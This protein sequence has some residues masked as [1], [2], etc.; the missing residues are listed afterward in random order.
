M[1][2][3]EKV[4]LFID[5]HHLDDFTY[6]VNTDKD[7]D[8]ESVTFYVDGCEPLTFK[9]DDVSFDI[10]IDMPE[11]A[12]QQ[13]MDYRKESG[14][15]MS[16]R[17][18]TTQFDNKYHPVNYDHSSIDN[19]FTKMENIFVDLKNEIDKA[20][21]PYRIETDDSDEDVEGIIVEDELST[22]ELKQ[23]IK[24]NGIDID[25]KDLTDK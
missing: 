6:T 19:F 12:L 17:Y 16:Y 21:S 14:E 11:D 8:V 1:S 23:I 3:E 20:F 5:K 4:E 24:N 7:G 15:D 18:W 22:D 25:L 2:D 9:I 13:W 10:D